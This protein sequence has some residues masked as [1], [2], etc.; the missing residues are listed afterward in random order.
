MNEE[1][2]NSLE[3]ALGQ[4][5]AQNKKL[6]KRVETLE[7]GRAITTLFLGTLSGVTLIMI[8]LLSSR[9]NKLEEVVTGLEHFI[10]GY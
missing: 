3:T 10:A 4:F 6:E 5:I 8:L 7:T 2:R 9:I 1:E